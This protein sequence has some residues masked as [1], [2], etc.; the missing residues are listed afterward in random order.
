MFD[1]I[2]VAYVVLCNAYS[3]YFLVLLF[4]FVYI[5]IVHI[6]FIVNNRLVYHYTLCQLVLAIGYY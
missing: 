6:I 5:Y 2:K 1:V 3:D 4:S